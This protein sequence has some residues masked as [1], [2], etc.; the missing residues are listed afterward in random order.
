MEEVILTTNFSG[1][2]LFQ[3]PREEESFQQ[4]DQI[5]I[6]LLPEILDRLKNSLPILMQIQQQ[7]KDQGGDG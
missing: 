2:I 1:I 4:K 5:F 6:L 7:Y 3:F